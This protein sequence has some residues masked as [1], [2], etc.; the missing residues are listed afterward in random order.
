MEGVYSGNAFFRGLVN[1]AQT[2]QQY[3]LE[4]SHNSNEMI[5]LMTSEGEQ[6]CTTYQNPSFSATN[7]DRDNDY[8]DIESDSIEYKGIIGVVTGISYSASQS[9]RD[10][11]DCSLSGIRFDPDSDGNISLGNINLLERRSGIEKL[12]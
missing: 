3:A 9:K 4:V 11:M 1:G 5:F 7:G 10:S 12:C 2:N 6:F 8:F